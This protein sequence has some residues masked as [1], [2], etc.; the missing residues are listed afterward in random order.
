VERLGP[1]DSEISFQGTFSGPDAETRA[2]AFDSLRLSG[3]IV[4]LTWQSFRRRVIVKSFNAEYHSSS[5]IPYRVSCVVVHQDGV[6]AA[7]PSITASL[8][9]A[10]LGNAVLSSSGL[11]ISFNSLQ[12]ALSDPNA[13]TDGTSGKANAV[14]AVQVGLSTINAQITQQSA[15]LVGA[16][17]LHSDPSRYSSTFGGTV[18]SAG[19]L[20]AAVSTRSYIGRI[21]VNLDGSGS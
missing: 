6:P 20:A 16:S 18:N 19:L 1:D 9:L 4:W 11:P 3:D 7:G 14:G 2:R 15:L 8:V 12:S 13:F 10:D 5:W 21:G 17:A